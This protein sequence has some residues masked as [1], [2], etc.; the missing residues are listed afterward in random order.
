MQLFLKHCSLVQPCRA[1][2]Q[3][4]LQ[5]LEQ[6]C[7][8]PWCM[9]ISSQLLFSFLP[10]VLGRSICRLPADRSICRLPGLVHGQG[11]C[12]SHHVPRQPAQCVPSQLCPGLQE[13]EESC[14]LG[15]TCLG[16]LH[17]GS[18]AATH[19]MHLQVCC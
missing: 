17:S 2:E 12:C 18:S 6:L 16:L 5:R 19:A 7:W 8:S 3:L 14:T 10:T 4:K 11:T 9:E 15:H 1:A 13:G